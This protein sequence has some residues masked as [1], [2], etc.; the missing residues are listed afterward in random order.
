MD[1]RP[2]A[3][4]QADEGLLAAPPLS[5]RPRPPPPILA[6]MLRAILALARRLDDLGPTLPVVAVGCDSHDTLPDRTR[7]DPPA[8]VLHAP[9]TLQAS[10]LTGAKIPLTR[11]ASLPLAIRTLGQAVLRPNDRRFRFQFLLPFRFLA[12]RHSDIAPIAHRP[13]DTRPG[14][15]V[16]PTEGNAVSELSGFSPDPFEAGRSRQGCRPRRASST[17]VRAQV[18]R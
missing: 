3:N 15:I 14:C 9:A 2:K 16:R 12:T 8:L 6:V 13:L 17:I 18:C 11:H 10:R 5:I 4:C 1:V 7:F